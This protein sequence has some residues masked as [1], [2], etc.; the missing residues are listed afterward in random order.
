MSSCTISHA[1]RGVCALVEALILTLGVVACSSN[2]AQTQPAPTTLNA[3]PTS[4]NPPPTQPGSEQTTPARQPQP[5]WSDPGPTALDTQPQVDPI[6]ELPPPPPP[7]P[8][9]APSLASVRGQVTDAN[10]SPVPRTW[11]EFKVPGCYGCQQI[12][13]TTDADGLYSIRL[14]DGFYIAL[15]GLEDDP[16]RAC[17]PIGGNGGPYAVEVPPYDQE[18]NFS[19]GP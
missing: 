7:A 14:P 15:C 16:G 2:P 10:G 1:A 5:T 18:I 11:V 17:S 9:A 6:P 13:T 12:W 3:A 8:P 19:V 4:T